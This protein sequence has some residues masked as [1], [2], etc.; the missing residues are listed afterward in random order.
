MVG[1]TILSQRGFAF[2]TVAVVVALIV[3]VAFWPRPQ[4]SDDTFAV[5]QNQMTGVALRGYAMDLMT[6][7]SMEIQSYLAKNGAPANYNFP[8]ALEKIPVTGCA[9]ES[10]QGK[11]VSM[12]CFRTGKPLAP[13][14]QSDLWL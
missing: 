13:G 2:A 9:I 8:A 7:N 1:K 5:Y 10:W 12:I 11:K 3:L 6:T 14:A 4:K